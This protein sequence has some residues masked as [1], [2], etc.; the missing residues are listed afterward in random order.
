MLAMTKEAGSWGSAGRRVE[1]GDGI[2]RPL[3]HETA[4]ARLDVEVFF[5]V[6]RLSLRVKHDRYTY[7]EA[8]RAV[9]DRAHRRIHLQ[10]LFAIRHPNVSSTRRSV[11]TR[12]FQ[13]VNDRPRQ[14]TL[15][16][17][18]ELSDQPQDVVRSPC[19]CLQPIA[20]NSR[21]STE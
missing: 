14:P 10:K 1:V 15:D 12:I 17:P 13:E 6:L 4:L 7:S 8:S 20:A 11:H 16:L 9:S 21:A 3:N 5:Q 19:Q 18:L 2:A